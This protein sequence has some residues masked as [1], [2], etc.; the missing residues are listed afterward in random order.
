[1][2]MPSLLT[3]MVPITPLWATSRFSVSSTSEAI[4]YPF[5]FLLQF[6]NAFSEFDR[7]CR[8][9]LCEDVKAGSGAIL[10]RGREALLEKGQVLSFH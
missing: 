7:G 4:L 5:L 9:H 2:G 10:E 3:M 8:G 1:M 6:R